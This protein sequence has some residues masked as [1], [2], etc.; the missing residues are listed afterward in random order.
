MVP[1]AGLLVVGSFRPYIEAMDNRVESTAL[2]IL[3]ALTVLLSGMTVPLS[4]AQ[5][6][7]LAVLIFVPAALFLAKTAWVR[8]NRLWRLR[9]RSKTSPQQQTGE[10]ELQAM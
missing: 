8:G 10:H 4:L 5:V 7:G 2:S 1:F 9:G 3:A 6:V